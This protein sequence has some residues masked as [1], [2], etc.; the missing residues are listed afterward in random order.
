MY[1][2][3]ILWKCVWGI[4]LMLYI[5]YCMWMM[6]VSFYCCVVYVCFR[7]YWWLLCK[8][9]E[10][11]EKV[12]EK[13]FVV[14]VINWFW[15]MM[16]EVEVFGYIKV[17]VE[18]VGYL[19][20]LNVVVVGLCEM[21]CWGIVVFLGGWDY[22]C[23]RLIMKDWCVYFIV[24]MVLFGYYMEYMFEIWNILLNFWVLF[25]MKVL[26]LLLLG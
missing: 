17:V 1:V 24:I 3:G 9:M 23:F 22:V 21:Y 7:F 4:M 2:F 13:N 11:F 15:V 10:M 8:G 16:Y 19:W 25:Y 18:I 12:K 14:L 26:L 20:E 6:K 5:M